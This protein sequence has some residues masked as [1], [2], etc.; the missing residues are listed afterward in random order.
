MAL[1]TA[2]FRIDVDKPFARA[3]L[4]YL[5][6][7]WNRFDHLRAIIFP[8]KNRKAEHD[9][10]IPKWLA[11][12]RWRDDQ[13]QLKPE[14]FKV[15]MGFVLSNDRDDLLREFIAREDMAKNWLNI[16]TLRELYSQ[17]PKNSVFGRRLFEERNRQLLKYKAHL[18]ST[19]GKTT[20]MAA[21]WLGLLLFYPA[22]KP[23]LESVVQNV[24][25]RKFN[26][27]FK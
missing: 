25:G 16:Q 24:R 3:R 8:D 4:M 17:I 26:C 11:D 5:S 2:L 20:H 7:V 22:V 27:M 15:L 9:R 10:T 1:L 13:I 12:Y 19:E 14:D 23:D 18:K 6:T 21:L